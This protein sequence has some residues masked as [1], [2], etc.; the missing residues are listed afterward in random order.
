MIELQKECQM[1]DVHEKDPCR[2]E[3]DAL[4]EEQLTKFASSMH[5]RVSYVHVCRLF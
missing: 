1:T 3:D 2:N 5:S 4:L